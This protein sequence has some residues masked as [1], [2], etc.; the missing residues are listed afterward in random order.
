MDTQWLWDRNMTADQAKVILKDENHPRFAEMAAL[1]LSRTNAPAEVFGDYFGRETFVKNWSR[2][3]RRMRRNAWNDQRIIFW[4]AVFEK[5]MADFKN[6]G[7]SIRRSKERQA[8]VSICGKIG[9]EIR[10]TREKSGLTQSDLA[11]KLGVAQQ[12]VSRIEQ[13]RDN[14]SLLTLEKVAGGLGKKVAVQLK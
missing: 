5:L 12:V 9:K 10:A 2:I 4:Q 1:L 13:G 8:V 6:K 7:I 11:R 14:I 3:K